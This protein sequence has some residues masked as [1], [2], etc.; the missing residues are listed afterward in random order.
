L[1]DVPPLISIGFVLF[2]FGLLRGLRIMHQHLR[3]PLCN[4]LQSPKKSYPHRVCLGC[5]AALSYGME[6]S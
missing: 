2:G 1:L 6:D 5:G 4:R 3:C